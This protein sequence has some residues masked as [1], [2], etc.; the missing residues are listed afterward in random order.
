VKAQK[1]AA[2]IDPHG[3][4]AGKKRRILVDTQ[5]PLMVAI[6]HSA[7][8]QDRGGGELLV[9][10][11]FGFYPFLIKLYADG[12]YQGRQSQRAEKKIRRPNL[13]IVKRFD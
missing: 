1:K 11:P 2:C 8:I 10:T 3:Y 12:G 9:A 4:D 5:G 13:K 7:D 6:V